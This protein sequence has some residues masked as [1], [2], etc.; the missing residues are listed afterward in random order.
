MK[1]PNRHR[2]AKNNRNCND[3]KCYKCNGKTKHIK[4]K[5]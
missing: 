1:H 4:V 3:L 2:K 5:K